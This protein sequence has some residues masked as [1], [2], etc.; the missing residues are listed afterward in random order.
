MRR[1]LSGAR[2]DYTSGDIGRAIILLAIPMVLEVVLESVFAV[3]DIFFVGRLGARAVATVG[4][5]E[6]VL[7]IVYAI[8]MGL[9]VAVTATV[10]RRIGERDDAGASHAAAQGIVIGLGLAAV[11]GVAGGLLAPS[12]LVLLGAA[13]DVV[14]TGSNYARIMLG[15][16]VSVILLFLANAIFRGAGDAAIA[17]RVLWFANGINILLGPCLIFGLGPFPR[18]GVTGAAIATTIG[19]GS[20]ALFALSRLVRGNGRVRITLATARLDLSLVRRMLALSGSAMVQM[21]IGTASWVGLVRIVA[22]FGDA[23]LAGYTIGI[24]GII[25][26]LLPAFGVSNA[27]AT[28][29]GQSLGAGDPARAERAVWKAA[30]YCTIFLG[31]IGVLYTVFAGGIAGIFTNDITVRIY[32]TDCLRMISYGF[33]IYASGMVLTQAF[34]GAGDTWT[35]TY[36][37]IAVFWAFEIPLAY[38]LADKIEL[39]PRGVFIAIPVAFSALSVASAL[40]F[41]LG[42]WKARVV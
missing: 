15:G 13:P 5:T 28:M 33:V 4:L 26:A 17:M 30:L 39:G 38:F 23:A 22:Q 32:A 19:R 36:L 1:S 7:S 25:F 3:T 10:A 20:G 9:S 31:V 34:N 2:Y 8:A 27:A 42:R 41:R 6:S 16:E 11:L 24:R 14:A 29:V 12:I 18:L 35:P 21:L 37:N 40:I